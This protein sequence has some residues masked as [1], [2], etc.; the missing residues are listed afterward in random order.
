MK[1]KQKASKRIAI[2]I[3]G[4]GS[5]MTALIEA[6]KKNSWAAT[7]ALIVSNKTDAAGLT[8]AHEAGIPSVVVD[9]KSFDNR[10]AFER[11]LSHILHH[12]RI[13]IIC[14]AGFMRLLSSDFV[15]Q[16]HNHILNIHPSLLPAYKGLNTHE[17]A[18]HD[19]VKLHGATVHF[20]RPTMDVGP[21][22]AQGAIPV[23]ADDT[24]E[25]LAKRVL[26]EVEH[27]IYPAALAL[28][29]EERITI[30]NERVII[31]NKKSDKDRLSQADENTVPPSSPLLSIL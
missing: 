23:K 16:W 17:R 20:V 27:K 18:L 3:S 5:N 12:H 7:I 8:I 11:E 22:I 30:C 24:A 15:E 21:I 2:F 29:I 9:H 4:R 14:L 25:S 28:V 10:S 1:N 13:D 26:L 6:H 31:G 19:G